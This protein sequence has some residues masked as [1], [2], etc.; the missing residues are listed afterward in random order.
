MKLT[1]RL[2]SHPSAAPVPATITITNGRIAQ[3]EPATPPAGPYI[4]AGLI[5]SHIHPLEA[6]LAELYPNLT[7]VTS[8]TELL[9]ALS[10]SLN[11]G[12]D[13]GILL[14]FNLEPD[15]LTEGRYPTRTEIDKVTGQLP[16]MVYRVDGHSAVLNSAALGLLADIPATG[17]E[18]D[19][20]GQPTGV[21]RG[22][23]Y[24][25]ASRFFKRRLSPT[26]IHAALELAAQQAASQGVTTIGA[27]VGDDELTES[28]WQVLIDGLSRLNIT[29]IPY[30]QTWNLSWASR[31]GLNQL[32][33]CL[34]ID[35]SFGSRTAALEQDY[36]DAPGNQGLLYVTDDRLVAF[37]Q[38][39]E[40]LGIATAVHAIGDRA[41]TQ[42]LRCLAR[43]RAT[44]QR[45]RIE[46][47]ELLNDKLIQ[48]IAELAVILGVQPVFEQTW[49]GPNGMYARR[50]GSRWQNTNPFRELLEHGVT[51]AGGS[52]API[53][54]INPIAGI[55]AAVEHPNPA[56]RIPPEPALAMFTT[57]AALAL[58]LAEQIGTVEQAKQADLTLLTTDPR[59]NPNCAVVATIH[60]GRFIYRNRA[61]AAQYQIAGE[62]TKS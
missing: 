15:N 62:E 56:E 49:G 60:K 51:L 14:A 6:G 43:A 24:E 37:Y 34:L 11:V 30:L 1:G 58:Q 2:I 53:T 4:L 16:A 26:T 45:H 61:L 33:G 57:S 40:T 32:G 21:I 12:R 36:A 48:R 23:A 50:L 28:A 5:D 47:A 17:L 29:A 54:P 39:A 18:L 59:H 13:A 8:I 42:V 19:V 46:H 3:I 20:D 44:R 35:G 55:R 31:F 7:T 25:Y 22:P 38:Q 52:D 27:F 10:S 9:D 41:I